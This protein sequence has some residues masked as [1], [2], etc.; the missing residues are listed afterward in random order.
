M[1]DS[2][3][4]ASQR[5]PAARMED[6]ARAAGV[7]MVTV[8]RALNTPEKLAP[9]T[10]AAVR[11][12][13]DRLR[14]VHNLAAGS[15]ASSRSRIV[16]AI[17]P[18]L[19]SS[20]FSDTIDGIAQALATQHYQL[21]LGQTHYDLE[22]EARLV[23]AFLGRRVDGLVLIGVQHARGVR[24]TLQRAAIPVVE[25]WD[26]TDRPIDRVV[27][28]SNHAA[29]GAAAR[30]LAGK[31][32]RPLAFLGGHDDRS[33]ARL[34]GYRLAARECGCGDVQALLAPT[35]ASVLDGRAA[36]STLMAS[37][38]PPR[39]VFCTNDMLAAGVLFECQHRGIAVPGQMAVMGF[40][41]LPIAAG[42]EPGLTSV[43]VHAT[44][45]GQRAGDVLLA[46]MTGSG[47]TPRV[48]DLGFAVV[49]RA[50][51]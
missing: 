3:R 38:A 20:I 4:P 13:I 41:D 46:R 14:Y 37:A 10:L 26:L 45:M 28:F 1:P 29:G 31:G 48:V 17:V 32:Y 25:T 2:V 50:S 27:G 44:A 11:A 34:D 30:Y 51:A 35:P 23:A 21:L 7:S 39:A 36:L 12:A 42:T 16:A 43:Q 8:S 24:A 22:T 49:E 33:A 5:P 9:A 18:T 40:A 6:V 15:L 47:D 19:A